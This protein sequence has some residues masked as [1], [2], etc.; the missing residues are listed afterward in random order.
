MVTQL[1]KTKYYLHTS[2][3]EAKIGSNS[4]YM[5]RSILESQEILR[6]GVRKIIGVG[7]DTDVWKVMVAGLMQ[8]NKNGCEEKILRDIFNDR[9]RSLINRIPLSTNVQHDLWFWLL[10]Q[11]GLFI[12]KSCYRKLVGEQTGSRH[13]FGR[14]YS[15]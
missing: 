9:D 6:Q 1:M 10:E 13:N 15:H 12:V 2:F 4:S 14:N 11:T 3:L 5:W 7:E 8:E